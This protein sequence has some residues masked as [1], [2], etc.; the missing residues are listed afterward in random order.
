MV[1]MPR[2]SK[3]SFKNANG[4]RSK[5]VRMTFCT[6]DVVTNFM[7]SLQFLTIKMCIFENFKL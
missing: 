3:L 7:I 4:L 6:T 5:T 2:F 1:L